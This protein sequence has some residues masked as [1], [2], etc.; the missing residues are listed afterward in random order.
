M[1]I[2]N[3][4]LYFLSFTAFLAGCSTT[5][6]RWSSYDSAPST[7]PVQLLYGSYSEGLYGTS[8]EKHNIAVMLPTSGPYA[9]VGQ[10]IRPAIE[11]AALKFAP[12]SLK[13]NFYDTGSGDINTTVANVLDASPD[14][15]IGPVFA[16][17]AKILREQKPSSLP[18]LSFTSDLSAVGDGVF[19]M[20]LVPTNTAEALL[21]TMKADAVQKFII[22]APNNTSGHLM[23]GAT[24]AVNSAYNIE[25]V[26][27]F[28]YDE[29]NADSIKAAT[30]DASMF[31][32][33]SAANT[34]AKEILSDILN[35]EQL[36][37]DER[38]PLVRQLEKI[39]KRDVLG[40]LPYDAIVFLGTA[41]DT[42]SLVS[43][44]R[45]YSI[46][47]KDV[48]LYGTSMWDDTDISSD[49]T[50]TDARY[51]TLPQISESFANQYQVATNTPAPRIAAIGYDA[52][53]LAIGAL[54]N[55]DGVNEYLM[56]PSGYIGAN[57]LFRLRPNGSNERALR[58]V[59]LNGDGTTTIA[60]S[61][62]TSFSDSMYTYHSTVVSPAE[63]M[64]LKTD[65]INPT[66]YINIPERLRKKYR[67]KTF[68]AN[69]TPTPVTQE[70]LPQVTVLQNNSDDFSIKSETYEPVT[71]ENVTRTYID[72]VEVSE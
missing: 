58:I 14:L 15:I 21:K 63:S 69:Q 29:K 6:S 64:P 51:A 62:A 70:T 18:V 13:F 30:L 60:S 16:N 43:F 61:G 33:R 46:G 1:N 19:S 4:I 8:S 56:N 44:L 55:E 7:T 28:Y 10:S 67:S 26:G 32:A 22:L 24:K 52:T 3:K 48:K 72:S 66:K 38:A 54:Y 45:Y 53:I 71:L 20:S 47:A 50:L 37:S 12:K 40:K 35:N 11:A 36:S 34:R 31:N 2:I 49:I 65:G 39:K 17:N 9:S 23:A 27:V 25:N 68:G 42:K 57:G 5:S 59:R 41:D